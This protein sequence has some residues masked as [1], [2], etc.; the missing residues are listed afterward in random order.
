MF[1]VTKKASVKTYGEMR[2]NFTTVVRK[3][4]Q[5]SPK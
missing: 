3:E 2:L 5:N 4:K 1:K